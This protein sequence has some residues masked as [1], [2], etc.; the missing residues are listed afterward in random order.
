MT[1]EC[2]GVEV[3]LSTAR[4]VACDQVDLAGEL[5]AS[6][7]HWEVQPCRVC[8]GGGEGEGTS[9]FR[10]LCRVG[11]GL[12]DSRGLWIGRMGL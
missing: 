7:P 5:P 10:P 2:A 8:G 11:L 12:A 6:R 4:V 9:E 3:R 1:S